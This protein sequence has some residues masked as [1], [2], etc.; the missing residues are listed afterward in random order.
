MGHA[1][2]AT[3]AIMVGQ[4][5]ENLERLGGRYGVA[6]VSG[7]AGLGV[8]VLIE[9]GRR[10]S[11]I[12]INLAATLIAVALTMAATMAYALRTDNQSIVDSIW[13][14]GFVVIAVVSFVLS[15]VI[16]DGNL[17]RSALALLLTAIWGCGWGRSSTT[18]TAARARTPGTPPCCARTR[19]RSPRSC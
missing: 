1:F 11:V 18:A 2:G 7:A 12:W 17:V 13:G 16:A 15:L 14:I 5:A 4:C 19:G 8:A 9:R 10:I 6:A 3:G